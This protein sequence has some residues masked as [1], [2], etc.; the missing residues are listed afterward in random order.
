MGAA[1]GG[2]GIRRRVLMTMKKKRADD[3]HDDGGQE[4]EDRYPV[5]AVHVFDPTVARRVWIFLFKIEIFRYLSP[6]SHTTIRLDAGGPHMQSYRVIV[7]LA[8]SLLRV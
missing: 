3:D 6:D 8:K 4:H 2:D 7:R 5:D 1:Q